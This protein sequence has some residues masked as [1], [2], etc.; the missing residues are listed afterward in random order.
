[1]G[2]W[3]VHNP[4]TQSAESLHTVNTMGNQPEIDHRS[5]KA[6]TVEVGG[7][8]VNGER[9]KGVG[10][11]ERAGEVESGRRREEGKVERGGGGR[12]RGGERAVEREGRRR[13]RWRERER[14]RM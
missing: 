14:G 5:R 10:E 2:G 13:E 7:G 9:E 4:M 6:R 3:G 12:E 11:V 1:M 8:G